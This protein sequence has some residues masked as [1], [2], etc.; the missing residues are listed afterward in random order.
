MET[1]LMFFSLQTEK[2]CNKSFKSNRA[3]STELFQALPGSARLPQAI[4]Q[5]ILPCAS[6][7]F[8]LYKQFW[9]SFGFFKMCL[10][11]RKPSEKHVTWSSVSSCSHRIY[12]INKKHVFPRCYYTC[13]RKELAFY[14]MQCFIRCDCLIWGRISGTSC[15]LGHPVRRAGG[16]PVIYH[17]TQ[18]PTLWGCV[19]AREL[20]LAR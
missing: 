6:E 13:V 14:E 10:F 17:S 7:R 11:R 15:S 2:A 3:L 4:L 1:A 16:S 18:W 20:G 5:L 9:L 19:H 8:P 12:C